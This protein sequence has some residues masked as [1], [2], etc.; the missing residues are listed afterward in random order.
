[1]DRGAGDRPPRTRADAR[2][3]IASAT[4]RRIAS[5][6]AARPAAS[7]AWKSRRCTATATNSAPSSILDRRTRRRRRVITVV[8]AVTPDARAEAAFRQ[9]ERYR[10]ILNQIEDGCSRGR[11]AR[12][13]PVRQRRV[14]PDLRIRA[15]ANPRP[16][17]PGAGRIRRGRPRRSRSSTASSAPASRSRRRSGRCRRRNL[18]RAVDLARTRRRGRPVGFVSIYRD[19]TARKFAESRPA[20]AKEAAEAANRAKSEFLANMSHEIRTPMNG[21][22]RH[23]RAGA[24]HRRRRREQRDYLDDGPQ[25]R[26]TS[27]L[28]VI[29]DILDF[30]KIEA[31]KLELEPI[32]VRRSR[33]VVDEA[34]ASLASARPQ[35]GPRA[36][37]RS[38]APT[39]RRADRRRSGAAAA[40][41]DQPRRQ[42]GQVHRARR[43]RWSTSASPDSTA[44]QC[45][46]HVAVTRHRHRHRRRQARRRSSSRSRRP[47]ARRRGA[48]AAPASGLAISHALVGTDGRPH[49]A[50][51]ATPGAGQHVSASP[52]LRSALRR[53][54]QRRG[55][56]G[57]AS[58]AEPL[59]PRRRAVRPARRRVLLAEDNAVNQQRRG[60][61]ML[62]TARPRRSTVADDGREAVEA[63]A[64]REPFDV[65]LMDV[66][67]P[68][69]DGFEATRRD[70]R[71][72]SA[73][74]TATCRSSR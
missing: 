45:V 61:R 14:L 3:A 16:E 26:P 4:T 19:C 40:G 62:E 57:A 12:H 39:C 52:I 66:Q 56:G 2:S 24:R 70:P 42:R 46:L 31:G 49:L 28:A 67:M 27:L 34:L 22:H 50:S 8:R 17:L 30:S 35:E 7:S 5:F 23:D 20:G 64:D 1:M 69:M 55:A 29:N 32:A 71:D 41:P 63:L 9:C 38:S 60:R 43:G 48:S 47:T 54:A 15:R 74:R 18:Y 10:G 25:P 21:D 51:R 37:S 36:A 6:L 72:A 65:V 53:R 73:H 13:L 11:P 33:D 44:T 59:T 68:E 58:R